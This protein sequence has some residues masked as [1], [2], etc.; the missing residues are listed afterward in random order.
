M[1]SFIFDQDPHLL[2]IMTL[3]LSR[4]IEYHHR[5]LNHSFLILFIRCRRSSS[6]FFRSATRQHFLNLAEEP[7]KQGLLL[8]FDSFLKY[9]SL[10]A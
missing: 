2:S 1:I 10:L 4:M 6:A 5:L 9:S 3:Y 8:Y 7:Q